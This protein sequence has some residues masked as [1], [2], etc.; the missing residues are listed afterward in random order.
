MI[1]KLA[2]GA[3]LL[4]A[5]CGQE[6][7][8]ITPQM[9]LEYRRAQE[10]VAALTPQWTEAQKRLQT[11]IDP[12]VAACKTIGKVPGSAQMGA[13]LVCVAQPKPES[14]PEVKK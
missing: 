6:K 8:P 9:E 10:V 11:T 4:V 13:P 12:I 5:A 7:N 3:L 2:I 1:K 14:K